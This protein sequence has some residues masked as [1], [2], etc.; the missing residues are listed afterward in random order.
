MSIQIAV[1][2]GELIDKITILEIKYERIDDAAKRANVARELQSLNETWESSG[3]AI[4]LIATERR[5]L[6]ATNETLWDIEDAIRAK[7]AAREFDQAFID[8]ARRVY[9]RN[10][11]RAAIKRV[12]NERLGSQLSEEKSY[13]PY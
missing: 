8:L 13:Q 10:D 9:Q 7:E 1:S 2:Y 4:D 5:D 6:K 12:I 3:I 11:E